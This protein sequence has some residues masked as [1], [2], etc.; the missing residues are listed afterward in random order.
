M[1]GIKNSVNARCFEKLS[2]LFKKSIIAFI[3]FAFGFLLPLFSCFL[4]STAVRAETINTAYQGEVYQLTSDYQHDQLAPF[5][6]YYV[7]ETAAL[8]VEE[9]AQL[10]EK[11]FSHYPVV[12]TPNDFGL[13][14]S[15]VWLTFVIE[16]TTDTDVDIILEMA[17]PL[18]SSF[19]LY[20][21]RNGAYQSWVGGSSHRLSARKIR[22]NVLA[23]PVQM[24][25]GEKVRVYSRSTSSS[26]VYTPLNLFT[27]D[28]YYEYLSTIKLAEGLLLGILVGLF[29]YNLFLYRTTKNKN[30]LH[31]VVFIFTQI[32]Y[33]TSN[34]GYPYF[35]WPNFV[36]WNE[37]STPV[38][39]VFSMYMGCHFFR[40]YL[41][42]KERMPRF[43]RW[44]YF[45]LVYLIVVCLPL[46]IF[47]HYYTIAIAMAP[48]AIVMISLQFTGCILSIKAGYRPAK[49]YF[50]AN[51]VLMVAGVIHLFVATGIIQHSEQILLLPLVGIAIML[52]LLSFGLSDHINALRNEKAESEQSAIRAQV[53]NAAKSRFLAQM[54][55]EIRTPMS[56]LL[57]VTHLLKETS[58]NDRQ[59]NYIDTIEE[60]GKNLMSTINNILDFSKIEANKMEVDYVVFSI[61]KVIERVENDYASFAENK[62]IW[63]YVELD[64]TAPRYIIGDAKL[65]Y[66]VLTNLVD[67]AI[68][69]TEGGKVKVTMTVEELTDN[70]TT[71]RFVITDTGIGISQE[72]RGNLFKS[73][74]QLQ[75]SHTRQYGGTGL[76]LTVARRLIELAGGQIGVESE[77]GKGAKFWFVVTFPKASNEEIAIFESEQEKRRQ[78]NTPIAHSR[79]KMS[80]LRILV[81]EDNSVNR[82]VITGVLKKLGIEATVVEDGQQAYTSVQQAELP[83]DLIFMDCEMPNLDGFQS[84]DLIREFE[85]KNARDTVPIVALTAHNIQVIERS[86]KAR[87]MTDF[88]AKPLERA[89][90]R[91]MLN[92]YLGV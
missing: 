42:T 74:T 49:I 58:L 73:F 11:E 65:F 69:F 18:L 47:T 23:F 78:K 4:K 60:S 55:H 38:F 85:A 90:L 37:I 41:S 33:Y 59:Q 45:I 75:N 39:A 29:I 19:Q 21:L 76:G 27:S 50:L 79:K 66:T 17:N 30:Y 81:A 72:N 28:K 25:P 31:L 67:N 80:E 20:W 70:D 52:I 43:D 62:N 82:M 87:N 44:M 16:N 83:F 48:A 61:Q 64:R 3:G 6:K 32:F 46:A 2:S 40:V 24:A 13:I 57:G 14:E 7:D 56:G 68:K 26:S 54:T 86:E 35:L 34:M 63:L 12:G 1:R 51:A 92:K 5:I 53:Q 77:L 10:S 36:D 22:L 8:T 9:I 89:L 91:S 71:M 15:A 84:T 88:L